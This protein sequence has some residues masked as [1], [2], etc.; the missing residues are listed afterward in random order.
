[1]EEAGGVHE[2]KA[3]T[4]VVNEAL[5]ALGGSERAGGAATG[6]DLEEKGDQSEAHLGYE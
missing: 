4:A 1:L 3:A 6:R 2:I 5:T